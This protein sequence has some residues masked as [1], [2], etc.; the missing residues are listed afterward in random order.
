MTGSVVSALAE[1]AWV[2][3]RQVQL[4]DRLGLRPE[5]H[6]IEV[7]PSYGDPGFPA[8]EWGYHLAR[9]TRE[10]LGLGDR[11]IPSM[12][13]LT[14]QRLGFPVIQCEL[15]S[16]VAGATIDVGEGRRAVVVNISGGNRHAYVRRATIAH[17][18]G[19]LLYD[20]PRE[21]NSLRVDAYADLERPANDVPDRVEQRANAFAVELIAPQSAAVQE[22]L[23]HGTNQL[24]EVV[25]EYGISFTAARYQIWNGL[26]RAVPLD[27]LTVERDRPLDHWEAAEAF[28][29]DYHPVRRIRPSRAGRFSALVVRAAQEAHISWDTARE[30]LEADEPDMERAKRMLPDLFPTVFA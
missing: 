19:H 7:N 2:A 8:Y 12:R 22:H 10:I 27:D 29:V 4:E 21:L 23:A 11:R 28:T 20:P 18:L 15:G 17:E 25:H 26:E 1:A 13:E 24:D 16:Q 3:M 30:W 14:E 6:G 9:Q 5:P